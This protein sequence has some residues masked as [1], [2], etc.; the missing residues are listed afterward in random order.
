MNPK[1]VV[2]SC[3]WDGWSCIEAA[4]SSGIH[5]PASVKVIR[6]SCLS[7]IH[8]GLILKAFELK[9]DGVMLFGCEPGKC[10]YGSDNENIISVYEKAQHFLEMLGISKERLA[11]VQL[12][13]FDGSQF[14]EKINELS[15]KLKKKPARK[16][17]KIAS[18]RVD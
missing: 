5:Y 4:A 13:A 6:V 9:A 1:I 16:R 18:S 15:G 11:L 17:V 3:N 7:R 10:N 12:S 2:F 14:V 8:V